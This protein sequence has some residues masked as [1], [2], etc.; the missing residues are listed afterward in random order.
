MAAPR[1]FFVFFKFRRVFKLFG[2]NLIVPQVKNAKHLAPCQIN[3]AN[4]VPSQ[5]GLSFK[6]KPLKKLTHVSKWT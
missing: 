2:G 5:G 1:T 4:A 3:L 6:Y